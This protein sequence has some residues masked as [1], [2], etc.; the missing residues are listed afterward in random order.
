MSVNTGYG[1]VAYIGAINSSSKLAK[2][3]KIGV[4]TY[5][6]Y[7]AAADLSGYNTCPNATKGCKAA[8]L[9]QSGRSKMSNKIT[10]SRIKKTKMYFENTDEFVN[11]VRKEINRYKL[12]AKKKNYEFTVRFN[13]TSDINP[14]NL[15]GIERHKPNYNS[16][17]GANLI[18]EYPDVTFY[19]YT[20][21]KEHLQLAKKYK[22]YHLT[23]SHNGM[24]G[25][26][27]ICEEFLKADQNVSVVFY[28]SIPKEYKGFKVIDADVNDLRYLDEK[29][30]ICGLKYKHVKG[31]TKEDIL[32]NPF[33]IKTT[34]N[35]QTGEYEVI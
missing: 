16:V 17:V 27:Q 21:S 4:K 2:G 22:N 9:M 19:D 35:K 6:I 26:W 28:P 23:Y 3:D 14:T 7:L 11:I 29:G 8:C 15:N 10:E 5:G 13:A 30:V 33:I 20:K 31:E 25:D 18:A 1:K 12:A 32:N 24:K 34:L